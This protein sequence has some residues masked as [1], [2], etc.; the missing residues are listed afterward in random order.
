[1]SP[2]PTDFK[3]LKVALPWYRNASKLVTAIASTGAAL[4]SIFSFLYSFGVVGEPESHKTVGTF[5]A[6][7]LGVAPAA[8]TAHPNGW[9]IV[10]GPGV[11]T[12]LVTVADLSARSRIVVRQ[13]VASVEIGGDSAVTLGE[14]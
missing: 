10:R 11:A 4:V 12:I 6:S 3:P 2:L 8:D 5:G 7:W 1:M 13:T 9:V 14:G